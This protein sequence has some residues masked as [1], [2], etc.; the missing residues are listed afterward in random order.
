MR[1]ILNIIK[2]ISRIRRDLSAFNEITSG[3]Q[4]AASA[5]RTRDELKNP[6]VKEIPVGGKIKVSKEIEN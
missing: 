1:E 6:N 5:Q 4:E 3:I 2:K